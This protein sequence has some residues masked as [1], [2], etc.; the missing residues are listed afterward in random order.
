MRELEGKHLDKNQT[1]IILN[2][3][4]DFGIRNRLGYFMIDNI[5]SN[6]TLIS[7]IAEVLGTDRV[8]YDTE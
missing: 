3:L 2:V 1:I 7:V 8:F 4:N 5:K 6:N